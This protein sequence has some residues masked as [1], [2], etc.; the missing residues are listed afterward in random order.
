MKAPKYKAKRTECNGRWYD[1]K[2]EAKHAADLALLKRAGEVIDWLEQVKVDLGAGVT[3]RVDFLVNYK[4]GT[5]V[6]EE[7]KGFETREWKIKEKLFR[8]KYP[9]WKLDVIG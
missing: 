9:D 4:D 3:L 7:V 2:R 8:D 5:W 6:F 1:S